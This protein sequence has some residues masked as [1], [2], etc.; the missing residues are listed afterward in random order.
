MDSFLLDVHYLAL[1]LGMVISRYSGVGGRS[2]VQTQLEG[3][4]GPEDMSKQQV[5]AFWEIHAL[6]ASQAVLARGPCTTK[7]PHQEQSTVETPKAH[8]AVRVVR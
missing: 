2:A 6:L 3:S 4:G 5:V 7:V 8:T 1:C